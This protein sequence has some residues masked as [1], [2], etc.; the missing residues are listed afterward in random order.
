MKNLKK[1]LIVPL[2]ILSLLPINKS[3]AYSNENYSEIKFDETK[4][5][6]MTR[7][8]IIEEMVKNGISRKDAEEST[9]DGLIQSREAC[10]GSYYT[11]IEKTLDVTSSYK[12]TLV[13]YLKMEYG[14]GAHMI[15]KVNRISLR[16]EYNGTSKQFAGELYYNVENYKTIYYEVNGNF[17]NNG[18][19]SVT[20]NISAGVGESLTVSFGI[21]SS[22]GHYKY[23]F[24]TGRLYPGK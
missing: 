13:F 17:F 18:T 9:K 3:L 24:E 8:E 21:S 22:S 1:L 5:K 7:D 12:P 19:T 14:H 16:N 10:Y 20:N 4:I 2:L 11:A 15:S 23:F 6:K